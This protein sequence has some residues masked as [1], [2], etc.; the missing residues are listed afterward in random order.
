M[1]IGMNDRE[2]FLASEQLL[3]FSFVLRRKLDLGFCW[4]ESSNVLFYPNQE[5]V[6]GQSSERD[7][8]IIHTE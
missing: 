8:N 1:L 7:Y 3:V 6:K 5:G 4:L 2:S